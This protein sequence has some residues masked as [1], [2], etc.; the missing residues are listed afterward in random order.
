MLASSS[1]RRAGW[2]GQCWAWMRGALG[3]GGGMGWP[4]LTRPCAAPQGDLSGHGPGAAAAAELLV[5]S[6]LHGPLHLPPGGDPA[7]RRPRPVPGARQ[8]GGEGARGQ[9]HMS[10][11]SCPSLA[12]AP[13]P[14]LCLGVQVRRGL[15]AQSSDSS[16]PTPSPLVWCTRGARFGRVSVLRPTLSTYC[17][18]NEAEPVLSPGRR[19]AAVASARRGDGGL[20]PGLSGLPWAGRPGTPRLLASGHRGLVTAQDSRWMSFPLFLIVLA[21]LFFL[22]F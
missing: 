13:G 19:S 16:L 10:P 21:P 2:W 20:G 6:A 4:T 11:E 18:G 22:H 17:A 5:R 7:G 8:G 15:S 1:D 14:G 3:R 12:C 9:V